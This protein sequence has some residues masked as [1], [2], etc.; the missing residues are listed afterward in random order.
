MQVAIRDNLVI[1][2]CESICMPL[3]I[4][5]KDD[6]VPCKVAPFL[7]IKNENADVP[8]G[9]HPREQWLVHAID[10]S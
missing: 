5:E 1:P 8:T 4:A 10:L 2:N 3:M 9:R 6:W 7:W